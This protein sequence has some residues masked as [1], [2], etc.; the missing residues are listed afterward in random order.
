MNNY[1]FASK[2]VKKKENNRFIRFINKILIL[3]LLFLIGLIIMKFDKNGDNVIHNYLN[4]KNINF[5]YFNNLYKKYFG[6]I[7]P[8]ESVVS[9]NNMEVFNEDISYNSANKYVDG[10]SLDVGENYLVPI[11]NDGVVVFS[12]EKEDYGKTVIIQQSD[13]ILVWYGNLSSVNV[14]IYDYVNKGEFLGEVSNNL[15]LV[16]QGEDGFLDYKKYI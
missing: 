14:N 11:M 10:V 5:A 9:K 3:F 12:G 1:K 15:Y 6:D 16:F 8:F 7:L 2:Y 13:G 4:E